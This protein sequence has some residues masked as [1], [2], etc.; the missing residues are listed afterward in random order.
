HTCK[1]AI[2]LSEYVKCINEVLMLY[3][4]FRPNCWLII[5]EKNV[6]LGNG[7]IRLCNEGNNMYLFPSV[8]LSTLLSGARIISDD[9]LQAAT[10]C[11]AECMTGDEVVNEIIFP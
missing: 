8:G 5:C 11:L 2:C 4:L 3:I 9:M 7:E 6:D 10:E 1:K